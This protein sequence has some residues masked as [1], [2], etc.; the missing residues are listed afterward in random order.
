MKTSKEEKDLQP[1]SIDHAKEVVVRYFKDTII[2]RMDFS[3]PTFGK[4]DVEIIYED[5]KPSQVVRRELEDLLPFSNIDV[6]REFSDK[7]GQKAFNEAWHDYE[8]WNLVIGGKKREVSL[9]ALIYEY[10]EDKTL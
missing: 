4:L 6:T 1:F 9:R 3:Y 7:V 8:Y 10:L 2:T 5:F